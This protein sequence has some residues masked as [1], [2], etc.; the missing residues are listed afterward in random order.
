MDLAA[1][2]ALYFDLMTYR[3]FKSILES[4]LD[5]QPLLPVDQPLLIPARTYTFARPISDFVPEHKLPK[6]E[7]HGTDPS[8]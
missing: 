4:G 8:H 7:P 1:R 6:E 5:R 2:R 3:S